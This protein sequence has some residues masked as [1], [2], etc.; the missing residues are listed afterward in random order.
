[1]DDHGQGCVTSFDVAGQG[2]WTRTRSSHS[3][4]AAHGLAA[5]LINVINEGSTSHRVVILL[6]LVPRVEVKQTGGLRRLQ[7]WAGI[8]L[9]G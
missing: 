9:A 1:M 2:P 4:S 5:L 8:P 6:L 7:G 3:A